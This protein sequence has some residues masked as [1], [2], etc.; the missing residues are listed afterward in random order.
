[1]GQNFDI[2]WWTIDGGGGASSGG[3]WTATG[4]IG[5][6]DAA[7]MSG[8]NFAL[9]GGFWAFAGTPSPG[10]PPLSITLLATTNGALISW[11]SSSAGFVLQEN[12]GLGTANW[13][14]V[15]QTPSDD[16]TNRSVTVPSGPGAKFY[17][18]KK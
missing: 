11:P 9:D 1:M 12:S 18:L 5:Q 10:V 3:E 4:T 8:G 7:L 16:G 6:P 14:A 15:A 17:R 13:T 2:S